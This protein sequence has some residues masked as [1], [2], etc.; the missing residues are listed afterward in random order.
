MR[1]FRRYTRRM[2]DFAKVKAKVDELSKATGHKWTALN[3]SHAVTKVNIKDGLYEFL[4][5]TGMPVKVFVNLLTGEAKM[6]M[7]F[8]FEVDKK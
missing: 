2:E 1:W 7:Y 4:P 8:V 6:F 5:D 3:G